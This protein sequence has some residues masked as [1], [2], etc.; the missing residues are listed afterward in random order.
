MSEMIK[1]MSIESLAT[2]LVGLLL[3]WKAEEEAQ[4]EAAPTVLDMISYHYGDPMNLTVRQLQQ[5]ASGFKIKHCWKMRKADLC[6][7]LESVSTEPEPVESFD[8]RVQ[9]SEDKQQ[10]RF[11]T[12][13]EGG[14][15]AD[16]HGHPVWK[17]KISTY[18]TWIN[19]DSPYH[20]VCGNETTKGWSGLMPYENPPRPLATIAIEGGG[21]A[22][23]DERTGAG[24]LPE[25]LTGSG[26]LDWICKSIIGKYRGELKKGKEQRIR[27]TKAWIALVEQNK[28]RHAVLARIRRNF[29]SRR[30]DAQKR[31]ECYVTQKQIRELGEA[32]RAAGSRLSKY[33]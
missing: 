31:G 19:N 4:T 14:L 8:C 1:S 28:N 20:T 5:I 16:E 26:R 33:L 21:A 24:F 13:K 15:E 23:D 7:A 25:D 27:R 10:E 11:F 18:P 30:D 3:G 32:F 17:S 22:V 6:R 2:L 29:W 9:I 12:L